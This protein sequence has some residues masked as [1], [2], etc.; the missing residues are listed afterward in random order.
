MRKCE[1]IEKALEIL[2][3]RNDVFVSC[4]DELDSWNGFADGFRCF[5]MDELYD[6]Y[7]NCKV[8]EFLGQLDLSNFDLSDTYFINTIYGLQSTSDIYDVYSD[9][10]DSGEIL[11][12]L[13]D[14]YN[15]LDLS[16]IDSELDDLV[17][18]LFNEDYED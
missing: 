9:N 1:L 15:H 3:N 13:I 16:W 6:L 5:P 12:N 14:N 7:H 17:S 4:V 2:D 8:S 10:T 18:Q 11:D